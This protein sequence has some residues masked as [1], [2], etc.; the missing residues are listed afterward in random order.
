MQCGQCYE[1]LVPPTDFG[2]WAKGF[3]IPLVSQSLYSSLQGMKENPT[4]QQNSKGK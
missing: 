2:M 4:L 3:N 1:H